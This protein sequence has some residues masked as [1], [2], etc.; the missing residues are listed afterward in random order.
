MCYI[1]MYQILSRYFY[2][3]FII[4]VFF[5]CGG[6]Y[7]LFFGIM[8]LGIREQVSVGILIKFLKMYEEKVYFIYQI[9]KGLKWKEIKNYCFMRVF[10]EKRSGF[11]FF[12]SFYFGIL[13][14]YYLVCV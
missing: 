4:E 11:V 13:N 7:V 12:Q 14:F 3:D 5:S 10:L 1:L 6:V 8:V 9:K 2:F